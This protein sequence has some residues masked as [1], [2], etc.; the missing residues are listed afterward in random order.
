VAAI[1]RSGSLRLVCIADTHGHHGSLSVPGG[2]VLIHAGDFTLGEGIEN[3]RE[4][5][6][7]LGT[8]PHRHKIL[9]AGNHDFVF[10]RT[11]A[12]ARGLIQN[13]IYLQ[14]ESVQIE[15]AKI[16]GSPYTPRCGAGAFH[17]SEE[18]LEE[19]WRKM[20]DDSDI[21]VTHGPPLGVLDTTARAR[22]AGDGTLGAR[23]GKIDPAVHVFGHI[24]EGHGIVSR[25]RT[26]F[27]NAAVLRSMGSLEHGATV[28]DLPRTALKPHEIGAAFGLA[29]R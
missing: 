22:S 21:V 4:F 18:K 19:H 27:I 13:A 8:L 20:D 14:G 29:Q 3:I 6:R 11:T 10:A 15:G 12:F 1:G 23:I 9:I 5:D 2:D 7:W 25:G 24:H 26:T 28:I 16:F 17:L